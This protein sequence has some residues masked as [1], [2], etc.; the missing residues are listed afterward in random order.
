M[1]SLYESIKICTHCEN[2]FVIIKPGF[3]NYTEEIL[4]MF[5]AEGWEM[6]KTTIKTLTF[7]QAK[8]LYA[9]HKKEDWYESLCEYMSSGPS[10]A[11]IFCRYG[12][13]TKS[14][15]EV[16]AALKDTIRKK[17]GIDDCR[18]VMHSSDSMSAMEHESSIYF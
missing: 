15:Y 13:Q 11:I 4:K 1:K 10:R 3:L 2:I 12:Q 14:T 8:D 16:V 17:W 6:D 18:N 7:N 9:V 5:E